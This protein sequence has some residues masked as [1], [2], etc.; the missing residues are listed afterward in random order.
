MVVSQSDVDYF[1]RNGAVVLRNVLTDAE[2]QTLQAGIEYNLA[3]P[4]PLATVASADTDPGQFLEDFCNWQRVSQYKEIIFQSKLPEIASRLM[5]SRVVRLYHDHLL[6]KT[7]HTIQHTP[8]H[9]DQPYYNIS[10]SQNVSFWIPIDSVP[11]A[12]SLEFQAGSHSNGT[13]YLPRT[14]LTHEARWFP[15]GSLPDVPASTDILSWD[16]SPRDVIAFHML[17]VHGSAGTQSQRRA[18]SIRYLGDDIRHAKRTWRTSPPFEID[19]DDQAIM[20]HTL[21][22]VVYN[23]IQH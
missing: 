23:T 20:D 12:C 11:A 2:L 14:F 1:Q 8:W 13:W 4:S 17:T 9:Q 6:V 19:L 18:F 7:P 15:E 22:P 21:F 5:D 10:G 3:N 16:V